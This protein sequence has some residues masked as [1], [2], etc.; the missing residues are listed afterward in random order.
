MPTVAEL[1][2]PYENF[3]LGPRR[4]SDVCSQCFNLTDG[5]ARCYACVH[6]GRSLNAMV[7]ISYSVAGEQLHHALAGYKRLGGEMARRLT[8]GL[9]AVLWRYLALHE[10]CLAGAVGVG[11]FAQATVVPSSSMQPDAAHPLHGLVSLVGPLRGRYERM[12]RRS[13]VAVAPHQFSADKYEPLRELA[14]EAI[15]L[16]DDTWTM[17]ANAQSAAAALKRA[18]AGTVAAVVI[19]RYVN[20]GWGHNDRLLRRLAPPFEWGR[21]ALCAPKAPDDLSRPMPDAPAHVP[22][23]TGAAPGAPAAAAESQE[24]SHRKLHP[25]LH[26]L[27]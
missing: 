3:M 20:R 7:P 25:S 24:L 9:A 8:F 5:F 13:Q 6:G 10:R 18:G 27:D 11:G 15:L 26:I 12:L 23:A 14:G 17:G 4:G 21:C 1:S 19:G 2:G 22:H 16:I